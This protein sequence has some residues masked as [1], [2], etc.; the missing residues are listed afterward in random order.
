MRNNISFYFKSRLNGHFSYMIFST[1]KQKL[2]MFLRE[3]TS[4]KKL[5]YREKG[6]FRYLITFLFDIK[7]THDSIGSSLYTFQRFYHVSL[8]FLGEGG[9]LRSDKIGRDRVI[10]RAFKFTARSRPLVAIELR[11]LWSSALPLTPLLALMVP[12]IE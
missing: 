6:R 2:F 7:S 8:R 10:F 3:T 11:L 4:D 9:L 12:S 5:Y 1:E